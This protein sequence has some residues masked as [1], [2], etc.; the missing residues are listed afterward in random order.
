MAKPKRQ[1]RKVET[2]WL[3]VIRCNLDDVV[4]GCWPYIQQAR[5][6]MREVLAAPDD[7]QIQNSFTAIGNIQDLSG[8]IAVAIY[9]A[10]GA[11]IEHWMQE[12][13]G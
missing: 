4:C 11:K 9:R 3:V 7:P 8:M 5:K 10:N 13:F 2:N 1:P 6:Q 12:E